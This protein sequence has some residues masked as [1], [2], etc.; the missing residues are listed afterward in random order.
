MARERSVRTLTALGS[1]STA[2]VLNLHHIGLENAHNPEHWKKPLFMCP[3][4]NNAFSILLSDCGPLLQ[5]ISESCACSPQF[6]I[7][8]QNSAI[9]TRA[10][11][12][13]HL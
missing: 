1:A 4:I 12:D 7:K 2:H 3:A 8:L 5:F 11:F 9:N 6:G 13:L 10:S